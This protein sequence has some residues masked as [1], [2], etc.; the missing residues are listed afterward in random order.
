MILAVGALG[1]TFRIREVEIADVIE[2]IVRKCFH[3]GRR[4]TC[5]ALAS[6]TLRGIFAD[7]HDSGGMWKPRNKVKDCSCRPLSC[8][9]AAKR[10]VL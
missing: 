5:K 3:I 10:D 6:R 7:S 8:G 1:F 4:S 2:L 9:A